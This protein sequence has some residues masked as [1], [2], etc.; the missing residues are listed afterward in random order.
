[1]GTTVTDDVVCEHPRFEKAADFLAA[2]RPGHPMWGADPGS[3]VFRGHADSKWRLLPASNRRASLVPYFGTKYQGDGY[4]VPDPADI[5]ALL[6]QFVYA[7]ERAGHN[8]AGM[9]L[10]SIWRIADSVA[11]GLSDPSAGEAHEVVGLAQHHRL[12]TD[13]L[14]WTRHSNVA[15]YFAASETVNLSGELT[16]DIEV[17]ALNKAIGEGAEY[18]GTIGSDRVSLRMLTPRRGGNPNLHAQSGLFTYAVYPT[19]EGTVIRSADEIAAAVAHTHRRLPR[20]LMHRLRLPQREAGEVLHLLS[21][22]PVTGGT[23]FPG[24]DGVVRDVRDRVRLGR[25]D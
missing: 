12:P 3:W 20:P 1:V 15:A 21:L 2:L 7:L 9:P 6:R 4:C 25:K 11:Y 8:V 5:E 22:E 10:M 13:L 17:W 16:G 23:L 14:D 18:L 24:Y 19:H